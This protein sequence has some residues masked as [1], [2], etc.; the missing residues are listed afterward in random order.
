MFGLKRTSLGP[1]ERRALSGMGTARWPGLAGEGARLKSSL[2]QL[3]TSRSL[4]WASA[5]RTTG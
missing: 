5:A 3:A 1:R 2:A 4:A